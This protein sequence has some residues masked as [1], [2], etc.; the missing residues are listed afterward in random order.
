MS[1]VI[2][3]IVAFALAALPTAAWAGSDRS[4]GTL[5]EGPKDHIRIAVQ[6]RDL[7]LMSVNGVEALDLRI[8]DAAEA[9]CRK[10]YKGDKWSR[11]QEPAC[12]RRSVASVNPQAGRAIEMARANK[13]LD[14]ELAF[15]PRQ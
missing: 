7:D 13:P 4:M 10:L 15:G 12:V 14:A 8:Q 2:A 3:S 9:G 1:H 5:T 6:V 11:Q